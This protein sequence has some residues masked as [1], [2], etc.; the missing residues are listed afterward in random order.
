[1][2]TTGQDWLGTAECAAKELP[3]QYKDIYLIGHSMGGLIALILASRFPVK[4]MVLFAPALLL[5][6]YDEKQLE[7]AGRHALTRSK[8]WQ[9]DPGFQGTCERDPDDDAYLGREYWSYDAFRQLL[10][11][12]RLAKEARGLL[13]SIATDTLTICG[14][15]DLA[16]SPEVAHLI[17]TTGTGENSSLLIPAAGHLIQYEKNRDAQ[18]LCN[19]A[20]V[21]WLLKG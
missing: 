14:E 16:V 19:K 21:D 5:T 18:D 2:A 1:M 12:G 7:T 9:S 11:L 20:A 6:G 13:P 17:E 3:R 10:E 4:K 15:Q 8:P